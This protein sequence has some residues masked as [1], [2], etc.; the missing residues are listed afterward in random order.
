MWKTYNGEGEGRN[1]L[2]LMLISPSSTGILR[3]LCVCSPVQVCQSLVHFSRGDK[4]VLKSWVGDDSGVTVFM[5]RT[6]VLIV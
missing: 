2:E 5:I 1:R 4:H 3:A 6:A